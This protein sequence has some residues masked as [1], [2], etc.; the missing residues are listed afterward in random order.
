[1]K[2]GSVLGRGSGC[3]RLGRDRAGAAGPCHPLQSSPALSSKAITEMAQQSSE[4]LT[5]HRFLL[6]PHVVSRSYVL[7]CILPWHPP[8]ALPTHPGSTLVHPGG[9]QPQP[10]TQTIRHGSKPPQMG[11]KTQGG[12]TGRRF[13]NPCPNFLYSIVFNLCSLSLEIVFQGTASIL[14]KSLSIHEAAKFWEQPPGRS[15]AGARVFNAMGCKGST[16][17]SLNNVTFWN[18]DSTAF[19]IVPPDNMPLK[20][21]K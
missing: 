15:T 10:E 11:K 6:L 5:T 1:M 17:Q 14:T 13:G 20:P 3:R 9:M 2:K 8:P 19:E 7:L 18:L 21:R 12:W 4:V 16:G